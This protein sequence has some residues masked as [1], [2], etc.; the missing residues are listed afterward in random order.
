M[1][2]LFKENL[3]FIYPLFLAASWKAYLLFRDVF[4]FNADEAVVALMARH[5]LAG[6]HPAFFYGQAYMGSLDSYLVAAG[7]II[8]GQHVWVIRLVQTLLYFGT[9]I[10]TV[11]IGTSIFKSYRIGLFSA[12]LLA[13]PTVNVTLYTTISLGGYGEALL[14]GNLIILL[15]N[16]FYEQIENADC[17]NK[18]WL[19]GC[20]IPIF[21]G[22]FVGCG[23]WANGLTLVYSIPVILILLYILK[24]NSS[25]NPEIR[26]IPYLLFSLVGF[27]LGSLPWWLYAINNGGFQLLSELMGEAVNLEQGYYLARVINHLVNFLLLGVPVI[28]GLRPPW[29]IRLLF[30]P[31]IPFIVIFWS[32]IVTNYLFLI[33]K[34]KRIPIIYLSL[35][36][37]VLTLFSGFIL[38]SFGVDPSGRYFLPLA[39]PLSLMAAEAI[40]RL[41]KSWRW[42]IALLALVIV[43]NIA[44]TIQCANRRLPGLTTQYY[45]PSILDHQFDQELINFLQEKGE[46]YGFTNYWVSYPL[47]FLSKETLIFTPKLPY[48]L[49]FKYTTRYNRYA[50][51]NTLVETSSRVAYIT[52][53]HPELDKLIIFN[54]KQKGIIWQEKTIGNYHIFYD[55]S[56]PIKPEELGLGMDSPGK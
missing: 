30:W 16:K 48:H 51:Y 28:F 32:S 9:I 36:G 35:L 2:F 17:I 38:T 26:Q 21:F 45:P 53:N 20:G 23:L 29:E 18:C 33:W 46:N 4:P 37:V 52:S 14:L 25:K 24:K 8:F 19:K 13:V 22:G 56:R 11:F 54:F 12:L 44:G 31:L 50:P 40:T 47:A 5:I 10:T 3:Y 34:T 39:I 27:F 55:L 49:D 1:K 7:F 41:V 42:Q 6:E 43:Y 15:G